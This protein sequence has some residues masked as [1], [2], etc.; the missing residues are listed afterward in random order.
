M[1]RTLNRQAGRCRA[2]FR[3]GSSEK[4]IGDPADLSR[5]NNDFAG[6]PEEI[7]TSD[8][9]IRSLVFLLIRFKNL[10]STAEPT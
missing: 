10:C 4:F 8:P 7:R 6:A 2:W 3:G 1:S 5:V 9:Q